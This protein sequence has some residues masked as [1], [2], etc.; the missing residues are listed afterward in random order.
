MIWPSDG[1]DEMKLT[2]E[3]ASGSTLQGTN[4]VLRL[5]ACL[6]RWAAHVANA[7]YAE[8]PKC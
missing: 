1:D 6:S 5:D 3:L 4:P 7:E 8:L 2:M